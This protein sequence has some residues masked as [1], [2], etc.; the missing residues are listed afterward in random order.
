VV[1]LKT[2]IAMSSLIVAIAVSDGAD[3]I[4]N[5]PCLSIVVSILSISVVTLY[6]KL[7]YN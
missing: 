1:K 4:V 6:K 3:A 7:I 5:I 2:K